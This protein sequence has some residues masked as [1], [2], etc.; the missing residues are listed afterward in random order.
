[1]TMARDAKPGP[2]C[3]PDPAHA[4][5]QQALAAARER[6]AALARE[7]DRLALDC[8]RLRGEIGRL[9][10]RMQDGSAARHRLETALTTQTRRA[11]LAERAALH[12]ARLQA[13]P[14]PDPAAAES[15]AALLARPDALGGWALQ[16][17]AARAE[18]LELATRS[19]LSVSVIL[20][21]F[22]RAPTVV[23][24]VRSALGQTLRA[25]EVI[26]ADD[27]STDDTLAL[28]EDSFPAAIAA[29]H[30]VVL[31]CAKGG[32]CATRNAAIAAARG[33]VLAFLDSDNHWHPDHLLWVLAGLA[34]GGAASVYTGAHVHHLSE[35][36][37]R[38][39]CAPY[40]RAALLRQNF[41]DL[42]CFAHRAA[43]GRTAGGFDPAL[44]RLVDWDYILRIT[45]DA[46]PQRV[47]VATVEYFLDAGGL[48]NISL[49]APLEENAQRIRLKHRAEMQ[50]QGVLN[51]RAEAAL[52]AFAARE[53][54]HGTDAPAESRTGPE[55]TADPPGPAPMPY[56]GRLSLFVVLPETVAPPAGLPLDRL[57][58]RFVRLLGGGRWCEIDRQ[59]RVLA[60][61]ESLA[62][63]NYWCPDL[64]QPLPTAHQL[65][66][67]VAATQLTEIDMAVA[68]LSLDAPPAVAVR[69]LRN[70]VV[71]RERDI[72]DFALGRPLRDTLLGKVLRIPEGPAEGARTAE[73]GALLG[74]PVAFHESSAYFTPGGAGRWP[75]LRP[76]PPAETV[77]PRPGRPRVLVLA[78]KVAVGGVERNTVEISRAL[79][80]D[81][82]CLY[83]TLE[84]VRA[85]QGSLAHQ[86]VEASAAVLDLAEIAHH[87][88]YL[89]LLRRIVEIYAPEISCGSATARC[90]SAPRP[91][92]CA[93]SSPPPASSTSRSTTPRRAGSA[94]RRAGHPVLRPLHRHQ[95][96]DPR[97]LRGRPGARPGARRPDLFGDQRRALP[98]RPRR[99]PRPR[100]A[101]RGPRAAAGQDD[102]R[103]HGPARRAEAAARLPGPGETLP[104]PRRPAFRADRQRPARAP[105]RG[106]AGRGGPGERH[107]IRNVADTT[108]FWL[109]VDAYVVTS[110]YE[111]LP[112]ALIEA[113][114][115]GVP[116]L[117]TD[118]GDIRHVL[119][120][121]DAGQ[122]VEGLGPEAFAAALGPFLAAL[123]GMRAELAGRG[124][125]IIDFF[126]AETISR[127]FAESFARAADRRRALGRA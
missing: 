92:G 95:P 65:A 116:A 66:T 80:R 73:L 118:V 10:G 86:A 62:A 98:R 75:A 42:N 82:D 113:I 101:A 105:G 56:F 76:Q 88:L 35:H 27:A 99:R 97:P 115:M 83:L 21:T 117:S 17:S 46:A 37:T 1:M 33:D 89:D 29:G 3:A 121:Y 125:E 49:T 38:T 110:E 63:G 123:P 124:A 13:A 71:L 44:S 31:P 39:D 87:G 81:H 6:L 34:R 91:S 48:K 11:D 119:E 53:T 106:G 19:D 85:E 12:M 61:H 51:A 74:H 15:V 40:D 111:G 60:T 112:I 58:P 30:L 36:W 26:V 79:A 67:L 59:G 93:T 45:H 77:P 68:S 102:P 114:A 5:T 84:K 90:G 64:R 109:A 94:L 20:P 122:V 22:D 18:A 32:V 14:M 50:A 23:R 103:L 7:T 41:I 8:A 120:T 54:R 47:P 52:D 4:R 55:A 57:R 104:R 72:E 108:T 127:Q 70:Q 28:L 24:A 25:A 69:C 107:L 16:G 2:S 126:S 78:Q 100:R 43:A 9:E 96:Q